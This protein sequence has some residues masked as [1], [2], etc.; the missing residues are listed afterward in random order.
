MTGPC[1]AY[2]YAVARPTSGLHR[3]ATALPGVAGA[4]VHLVEPTD[5]S[6]VVAVVSPVPAADFD[7]AAL[8]HH[9]E[10]LTWLEEIARAHHHV[11]EEI[12]AHTTVL[13]LRLATVY[14]DDD[15][16]RAVL[17]ARHD[18]FRE[19][20]SQLAGRLEWGVKLYV[21]TPAAPPTAPPQDLGPGRAYLHHR[22][23][24]QDLRQAGFRAAQTA[25]ERIDAAARLHAVD[26]VRHRVQQG[27]LAPGPGTNVTNDA[28]LVE[29]EH[30]DAFHAA[31][32]RSTDDLLGVRVDITGP[33]APY[34]FAT[35]HQDEESAP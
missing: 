7:E 15:R 16:V 27:E 8:R 34:S 13:P 35:P 31:V 10:E 25:A 5:A 9:L 4:R 3:V 19:R 14:L 11:I 22:R 17:D 2:T 1:L 12:A 33:W 20:L 26:R 28:Y 30:A 24:E 23:A 32:V 18:A 21:D 29:T 6:E